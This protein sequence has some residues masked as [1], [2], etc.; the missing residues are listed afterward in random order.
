M[1]GPKYQL[2]IKNYTAR[3]FQLE[4]VAYLS[5][6]LSELDLAF[7]GH[8]LSRP[9]LMNVSAGREMTLY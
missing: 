6:F 8:T 7:V 5:A 3:N 2:I 4:I 1:V 9:G